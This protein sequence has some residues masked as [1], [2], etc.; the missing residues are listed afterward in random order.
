MNTCKNIETSIKNKSAA[1]SLIGGIE[2]IEFKQ[3]DRCVDISTKHQW[4]KDK[5]PFLITDMVGVVAET[6]KAILLRSFAYPTKY[7]KGLFES[8][9]LLGIFHQA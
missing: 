2:F 4:L 5:Y 1:S 6:E 9:H 3:L 8:D 7:P